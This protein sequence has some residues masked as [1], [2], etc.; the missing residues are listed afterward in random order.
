MELSKMNDVDCDA[1]V[2]KV[3]QLMIDAPKIPAYAKEFLKNL[4]TE[5]SQLLE[6]QNELDFMSK[7][8][9]EGKKCAADKITNNAYLCFKH[10]YPK[11]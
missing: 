11:A 5:I 9:T 10:I 6:L 1:S 3:A 8:I 7:M 2:N 4:Q